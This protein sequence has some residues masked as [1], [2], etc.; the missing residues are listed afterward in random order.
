MILG[1]TLS[2]LC[3]SSMCEHQVKFGSY[4]L[5]SSSVNFSGIS[6]GHSKL[7]ASSEVCKLSLYICVVQFLTFPVCY[8]L[9]NATAALSLLQG[10]RQKL[11]PESSW[12]ADTQKRVNSLIPPPSAP[13]PNINE[14]RRTLK[15][16]MVSLPDL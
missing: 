12:I 7:L 15:P 6:C 16:V 9:E 4:N 14:A 5:C 10:Y 13:M 2:L 11:M 3:L 8:R 1:L